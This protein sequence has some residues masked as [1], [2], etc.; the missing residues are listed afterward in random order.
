MKKWKQADYD[1]DIKAATYTDDKGNYLIRS[2]GSLPWR[3][4]N[5]GNLRPRLT[6]TGKPAPRIIK[7][8][9]GFAKTKNEKNEDCY[10]LIFPD[11]ETGESELKANLKRKYSEK[12]ISEAIKTYTP[13]KENNTEKYI[14]TI[15]KISGIS[16]NSI[17]GKLNESEFDRFVKAIIKVEGYDDLSKGQRV[18]KELKG[19]SVT[20]TDG[21][22]SIANQEITLRQN[23]KESKLHSN[24]AGELPTIIH[25][26]NIKDIELLIRNTKG[27][28]EE[29]CKITEEKFGKNLILIWDSLL[30]K[31]ST[32]THTQ[33]S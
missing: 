13:K 9:I 33:K 21:A 30:A 3:L 14:E 18:E 26:P 28:L 2:G 5:P 24:H 16:K 10:F 7:S 15:E 29:I 25:P 4:N 23:G 20:L 11:Y 19:T 8:H 32:D 12:T 22:A 1:C 6:A 17:I 31:S 27:N